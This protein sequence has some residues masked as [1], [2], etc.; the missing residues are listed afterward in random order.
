MVMT[1]YYLATW[2]KQKSLWNCENLRS[3][4]GH[5][6]TKSRPSLQIWFHHIEFIPLCSIVDQFSESKNAH[7]KA[8]SVAGLNDETVQLC[9]GFT[10]QLHSNVS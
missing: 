9:S 10:I 6:V 3:G 7:T 2:W 5:F 8:C 4:R 1:I